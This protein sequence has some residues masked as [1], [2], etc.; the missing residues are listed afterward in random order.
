LTGE[1]IYEKIIV[2]F[3]IIDWFR[4]TQK[5]DLKDFHFNLIVSTGRTGTKYLG[6]VLNQSKMG[7]MALHEPKPN[8]EKLGYDLISGK[9][10]HDQAKEEIIKNR[11]KIISKVG[12]RIYIESNGGMTFLLPVLAEIFPLLKI[13]HIIRNPIDFV[14]SGVNRTTKVNGKVVQKYTLEESWRLKSSALKK[15]P[16]SDKWHN[17]DLH[18]RFMWLWNL[19]NSFIIDYLNTEKRGITLRFEDIFHTPDNIGFTHLIEYLSLPAD[20]NKKFKDQR[21]G[22]A[23]NENKYNFAQEY[24]DWPKDRKLALKEICLGVASSLE[25]NFD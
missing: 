23:K 9:I 11:K 18:E 21:Y 15:D 20:L 2:M 8:F 17:M 6:T 4:Q 5:T 19:K 25:Y 12:N 13:V 22:S 14:K 10:T 1:G 24:K 3:N 7:I 16:Y